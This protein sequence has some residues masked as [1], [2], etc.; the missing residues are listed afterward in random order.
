MV[1]EFELKLSPSQANDEIYIK[2][3]I[4]SIAKIQTQ[5]LTAVKV[6]KRS[7][8][9]RNKQISINIKVFAVW[10]EPFNGLEK[11]EPFKKNDVSNAK[12]IIV[13]GAGPA[14]L[15]AALTLIEQGLR[16]IV[17]ERGK[18]VKRRKIDVAELNKK[19][20]LHLESNYCFGEG[21]AGTFSDGKIY[22]RS[23]KR[24]NIARVLELFVLHGAHPDIL[25]ESHPHLGTDKLPVI[26]TNIRNT[27]IEC[28]G[29]IR[30]DSK[31]TDITLANNRIKEIT[32]NESERIKTEALILATGHSARDIYELLDRKKIAIQAKPFAMGVRIEHPRELIDSIQYHGVKDSQLPTASYSLTTQ[33]EQRGVYSFCMCPGGIIVPASTGAEEL[34]VNGM[35]NSMRNSPFSNAGMAVEIAALDIDAFDTGNPLAGLAMQKQLEY[36]SFT[37]STG[38]QKAPAQR[39]VDFIQNKTSQSLPQSSY[40]PGICSSP[41]HEWLPQSI[42]RRL[43]QAFGVFGKSMNGFL[44]NDAIIVGVESRTSSPVRIPRNPETLQHIEIENLYPCAEGAGYAGGITSSALDGIACAKKVL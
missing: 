8:D 38:L 10:D 4:A 41:L 40:I 20:L 16:P 26:I 14:G 43:Q 42:G 5:N 12:E 34:V 31:L 1:Q 27:I 17:I 6:T 32:I 44:T 29:I 3:R 37:H 13:V 23:N 18:D 36:L 30:F 19:G 25:I 28:G 11:I 2:K 33:I 9:A 24:G 7:I 35:S 39:L 21:G 22:T 15:F